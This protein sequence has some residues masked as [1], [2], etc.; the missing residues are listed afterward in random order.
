VL[1]PA[2]CG[3]AAWAFPPHPDPGRRRRL[4]LYGGQLA[5]AAVYLVAR[6][7]VL[8]SAGVGGTIPFIDNPAA[9]AGAFLGRLTGLGSVARYA[10]LLLFPAR[11]SAD[12]SYDQIPIARGILDPWVLAGALIVGAV[13]GGLWLRRR[14]PVAGFAL[15]WIGVSSLLTTNIIVFIG[16]LLAERLMYLPSLGVCLLAGWLVA[17]PSGRNARVVLTGLCLAAALAAAGH[18][19][20]RLRDWRDDF[21]LYRSAAHVSPRSARIRYNLGNAYL[22]QQKYGDAEENYRGALAIYPGF[23]DARANL[24][25]ALLQQGRARAAVDVLESSVRAHPQQ[26]ELHVNLGMAYRAVGDLNRAAT[27]YE[28][29]L[30]IDPRSSKALNN[31]GA[32]ARSR[33]SIGEAVGYLRQA[34]DLESGSTVLRINLADALMAAE[35]HD[36]AVVEFREAYR[37]DDRSAEAVRGM[38]E[39]AL[40]RGD[41]DEAEARFRAALDLTPPSARAA[42]FLGY[43][44]SLRGDHRAAIEA[45]ERAIDLEPALADAHRSLGLLYARDPHER[46]RAVRHL[47]TALRLEPDQSE[48]GMIR[49]A[50]RMLD[51]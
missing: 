13:A 36:E 33:G 11:L 3:L 44:L 23:S 7:L 47:E 15:L 41:R 2:L 27:E 46:E 49:K 20:V 24:G 29:A 25:M 38:G 8:G 40:W 17:A 31:L 30:A 34:V 50:L 19:A 9:A 26:A 43:L 28:R 14:H 39:V 35:R 22:K 18:S 45:Y 32:I 4:I 37:R 10:L 48:A 12:Y 42:N 21:A 1:A 16:T 5:M 51:R 6:I